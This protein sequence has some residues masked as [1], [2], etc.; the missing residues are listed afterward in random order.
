MRTINL[1]L[2]HEQASSN[3]RATAIAYLISWNM[4]N[5]NMIRLSSDGPNDMIA[6]YSNSHNDNIYVIGAV[7]RGDGE[8]SFH[9]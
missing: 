8:Y 5:Y 4:D 7:K 6:Y 3:E 1:T 9:S 2:T